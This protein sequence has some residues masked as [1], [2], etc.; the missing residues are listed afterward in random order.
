MLKLTSLTAAVALA[1]TMAAAPQQ[2]RWTV[3]AVR[4]AT[5]PFRVSG[6]V[7]NLPAAERDR[8]IDIAM[9]VWVLRGPDNRLVLG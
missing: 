7:A 3:H 1:A 4:Y 9:T 8:M 5:L 6:L 2:S